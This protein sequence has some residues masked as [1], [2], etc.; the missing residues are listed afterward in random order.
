MRF[1]FGTSKRGGA[2]YLPFAFTEQGI[3]MLSSVLRSKRA[4]QVHITIMRIFVKLKQ[5]ISTHKE[6]AVKLAELERKTQTHDIKIRAIF[7]AIRKL[8]EPPL[9]KPKSR[10][11]FV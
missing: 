4:I 3:A 5:M 10:I 9:E 7:E 1:Q 2:R 8:M 6:L 11:G